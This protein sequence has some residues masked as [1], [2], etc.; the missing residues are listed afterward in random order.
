MVAQYRTPPI[1]MQPDLP[2]LLCLHVLTGGAYTL[3]DKCTP[4]NTAPYKVSNEFI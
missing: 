4:F 2:P 3:A 1:P